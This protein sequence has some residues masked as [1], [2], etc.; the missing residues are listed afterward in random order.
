MKKSLP[1]LLLLIAPAAWSDV[2]TLRIGTLAF[3]TVNWEL[4]CIKNE[5]LDKKFGVAL[6]TQT[7]ASPEAG[8][9]GLKADSLDI[10]ATDWIWVANQD[11]AG[12]D[13][14]FIP[15]STHAGAIMVGRNSSIKSIADLKGKKIGI[16]GGPLDKNWLLLRAYAQDK[17][18]L[19]LDSQADKAFGAPPLLNQQMADGNLDALVNF[20]HYATKLENQGFQRL[21]DGKD[22][23]KGLGIPQPMPN[24]GY[25]FKQAWAQRNEGGL[26]RFLD[27]SKAARNL[28]C[29]DDAAWSRVAALTHESDPKLQATLRKEYCAGIVTQWT[30]ADRDAADKVYRLLRKTGGTELTGPAEGLPMDIFW[31]YDPNTPR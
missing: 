28:L 30:A 3:G 21:V 25:V 31:P 4:A 19:D 7:L 22:I 13:Y 8:K 29:T 11:Q 14:R 15:Y 17:F 18:G 20:W 6:E 2:D 27:A 10:I 12:A 1:C 16:V 23:V 24:V 5:G 9:I 26:N